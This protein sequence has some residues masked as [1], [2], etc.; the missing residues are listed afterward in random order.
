VL[1]A[2]C[3]LGSQKVPNW[4][5]LIIPYGAVAAGSDPSQGPLIAVKLNIQT[6]K[7]L[8]GFETDLDSRVFGGAGEGGLLKRQAT[9]RENSVAEDAPAR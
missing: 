3:T 7:T 2:R 5:K 4:N 8:D 6:R 9:A 1:Q